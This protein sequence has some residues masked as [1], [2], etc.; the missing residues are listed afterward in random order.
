MKAGTLQCGPGQENSTFTL[1]NGSQIIGTREPLGSVYYGENSYLATAADS[2]YNSFQATLQRR[3]GNFTFLAAYTFSKSIDDASS[4]GAYQWISITSSWAGL[5][6]RS[7][8]LTTL[9]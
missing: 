7:T 9:S 3:A 8:A 2:N 6:R 4:F 5:F 1:P